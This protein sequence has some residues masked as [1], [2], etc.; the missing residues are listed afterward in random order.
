MSALLESPF[1]PPISKLYFFFGLVVLAQFSIAFERFQMSYNQLFI[2]SL[3]FMG[4][5]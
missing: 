4:F 1:N 3:D 2:F 5:I